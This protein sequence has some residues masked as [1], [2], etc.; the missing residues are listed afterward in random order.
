M[1]PEIWIAFT[2]I[3]ISS[4]VSFFIASSKIGEY[5][6][7][8][9]T[10]DITVGK[11]EHCGLRKTLA[12]TKTEVDK[13]LEFKT[14]A[15]K[16]IDKNLYKEHSPVSLTAFGEQ[17]INE[18]G[19]VNIFPSVR[20]DLVR[21]LQIRNPRTKYDAQEM[22]RGLMD[23]LTEYPAFQVLKT[24]AFEHGRDYQQILRAGAILL[25]DYY[26]QTHS[27]LPE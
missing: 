6:S 12:E 19:F 9:D 4:F 16:F 3:V 27:E 11:D 2:G 26:I 7:K 5:K 22:A 15:Q 24:Y 8:V 10:L 18:S 1:T 21:M 14:N 17:L 23:E 20:D 13:L 25:R